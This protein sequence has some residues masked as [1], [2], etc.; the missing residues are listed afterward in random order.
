MHTPSDAPRGASEEI[1][2]GSLYYRRRLCECRRQRQ[3]FILTLA[4]GGAR[5]Q[6]NKLSHH[7]HHHHHISL[8]KPLVG[9]KSTKQTRLTFA[10]FRVELSSFRRRRRRRMLLF[11]R[12][13]ATRSRQSRNLPLLAS[14]E[15]IDY[16]IRSCLQF[17][18]RPIDRSIDPSICP[19]LCFGRRPSASNSLESIIGGRPSE[20]PR[21]M[22]RRCKCLARSSC[23]LITIRFS[24]SV[25][26]RLPGGRPLLLVDFYRIRPRRTRKRFDAL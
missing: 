14:A 21:E 13:H 12:L 22:K 1:W 23:R 2:A 15:Q 18:P 24:S 17:R 5:K 26:R 11:E 7:N 20:L 6:S 9:Y 8:P 16:T 3:V 25:D 19:P 4:D 10:S